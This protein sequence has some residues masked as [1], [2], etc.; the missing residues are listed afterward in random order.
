MDPLTQ[1]LFNDPWLIPETPV[2]V[3]LLLLLLQSYLVQS[4][5]LVDP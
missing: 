1:V 5:A 2:T 4:V 3:P